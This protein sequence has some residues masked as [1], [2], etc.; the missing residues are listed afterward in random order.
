[1]I[2][3]YH[4]KKEE[5]KMKKTL[6]VVLSLVMLFSCFV[7]TV[8]AEETTATFENAAELM[9]FVLVSTEYTT[10]IRVV[11][12]TLTENGEETEI[13]FVSLMGAKSNPNQVNNADNL[14]AAAFNLDNA[15][16]ELV[17]EVMAEN[18]PEGSAVVFAG[19][20]LGGMVAQH[21]RAD[22]E[23]IEK[24]EILHTVTSGSPYIIT[25]FCETEGGLVR[26]CDTFDLIPYLSPATL[27]CFSKQV[28]TATRE[29]GGYF[30]DPDGAHNLSY[31]RADVWGSYDALGIKNGTAKISFD[32][33][34]VVSFGV[35]EN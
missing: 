35:V 17:K 1:M 29:N 18:I 21:L 22:A 23:L 4:N 28:K 12:G 30:L 32:L 14:L 5:K 9:S 15:Y 13:Y 3:F 7:F 6:C 24:Y 27:I 8:G 10:P 25:G 34:D 19:H 11:K 26:L 2:Y 31:L 33:S 20:S 16:S